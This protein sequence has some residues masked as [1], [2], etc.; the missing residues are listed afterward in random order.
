[1]LLLAGY[2]SD[3][4][5]LI[6]RIPN[7]HLLQQLDKLAYELFNNRPLNYETTAAVTAFS[8]I[9]AKTKH[10]GVAARQVGV[11]ED[12]L[13]IFATKFEFDFLYIFTSAL[14]TA[15]PTLVEPVN[16]IMSTSG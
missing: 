8:L 5:F 13:R 4:G 3:F 16:D 9:K 6:E 7:L 14:I 1:M 12:N 11:G 10:R 2:G 15:F